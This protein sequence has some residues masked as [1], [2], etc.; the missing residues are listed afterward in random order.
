LTATE[1]IN[2]EQ[3]KQINGGLSRATE[4]L[5][6]GYSIGEYS[7]GG[8]EEEYVTS[9]HSSNP[10]ITGKVNLETESGAIDDNYTLSGD[11]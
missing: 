1:H 6:G 5:W 2:Y 9:T 10:D 11:P 7:I 8:I 3:Q 4:S